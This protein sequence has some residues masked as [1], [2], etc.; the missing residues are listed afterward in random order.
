MK[1]FEYSDAQIMVISKQV[2]KGVLVTDF[3]SEYGKAVEAFANSTRSM[4]VWT[5][6]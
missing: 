4:E 2:E 6:A 1:K 5:P 3:G